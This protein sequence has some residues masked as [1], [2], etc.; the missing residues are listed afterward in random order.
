VKFVISIFILICFNSFAVDSSNGGK[1]YL[2]SDSYIQKE[3][4]SYIPF[5]TDEY[6]F[7]IF[8]GQYDFLKAAKLNYEFYDKQKGNLTFNDTFNAHQIHINNHVWKVL[9]LTD[10]TKKPFKHIA[11]CKKSYGNARITCDFI[12]N[13]K[14]KYIEFTLDENN[15]SL[16][17]E[18]SDILV[19]FL[20][21]CGV[22]SSC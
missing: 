4:P 1:L 17:N 16:I 15:F 9:E 14:S 6:S 11:S 19:G 22:K 10:E 12:I 13:Y 8:D 2:T 7:L 20:N 5:G 18:I 3:L 21:Q